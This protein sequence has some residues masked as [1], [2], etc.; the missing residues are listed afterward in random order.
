MQNDIHR[1][2]DANINRASEALR[3]IE[4]WARFSRNSRVL[5]EKLK[6]I[7]HY[8]NT[9]FQSDNLVFSRESN[10]DIGREIENTSKKNTV[11]NI[12]KA[13]CKRAQ[14][15]L[16]VL[17]E[18]GQVLN[19]DIK[20]IEESRYEI[21][22]IEKELL[23]NERLIRLQNSS[24]YLVTNR[25]TEMKDKDFFSIL[26]KSIEGGVNII[27]LREKNES[28]VRILE[29]AKEI[30][31]LIKNTEV[32][33]VMNDRVDLALACDADGVH[34]GQDDFPVHEARKITP[35]GFIIGLSTHSKEQ[36]EKAIK[37]GADYLGVGPVFQTP[38]KPDYIPATLNY[39]TWASENL[40]LP[41]FAIGGIDETNIDKVI[42]AGAKKVAV[43][44]AIMNT[45]DPMKA[46]KNI[47][48]KLVGS[49]LYEQVR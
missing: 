34:L 11:R 23:E 20:N 38:T 33:F 6:K 44:R 10:L 35:P 41:W 19:I 37:S 16:R 24:L 7:R 42:S 12:I 36:G 25:T 29:L 28:E 27:Q 17:G 5:T 43:V 45:K 40:S 15:A 9:A 48:E 13:N 26:E 18:Y 49:K 14:E 47:Q 32:L 39:V 30:K 46:T 31:T 1:I 4:E 21:Y 8:I 2:I 22:S 3:V